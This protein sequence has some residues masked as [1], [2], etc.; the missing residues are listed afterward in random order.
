MDY[1]QTLLDSSE[2]PVIT[3]LLLGLLTTISPC[4]LA[5]HITAIGFISKDVNNRNQIFLNGIF[6]T[7]G[8]ILSYSVLGAILIFIAE[9]FRNVLY[10][11]GDQPMERV[12]TCSG[13]DLDRPVHVVWR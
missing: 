1:L 13:T 7:L 2:I 8:R 4:P 10:T 11:K 12:I 3:A 5:T 9:R 6:Y